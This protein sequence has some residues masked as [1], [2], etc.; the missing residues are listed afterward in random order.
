MKLPNDLED[1]EPKKKDNLEIDGL[2]FDS[3][4]SRSYTLNVRFEHLA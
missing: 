3:L 2:P 1:K 4:A